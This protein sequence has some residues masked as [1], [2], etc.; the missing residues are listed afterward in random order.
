MGSGGEHFLAEFTKAQEL[1]E[2][3]NPRCLNKSLN[4][5]LPVIAEKYETLFQISKPPES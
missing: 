4:L 1:L 5:F 2:K 3:H